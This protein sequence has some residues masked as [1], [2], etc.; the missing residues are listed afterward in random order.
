MKAL[1]DTS[2][3]VAAVVTE[4]GQHEPSFACFQCYTTGRHEGHC[5]THALAEC[6]A[7]LTALPLKRRIQPAE[8]R[9]LIDETFRSRL[10]VLELPVR[11]YADSIHRASSLGLASGVIYD[12]LHLFCAEKGGCKRLYTLN[13]GDFQRLK[14]VGVQLATP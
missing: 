9:R 11:A 13:T 4:L 7:T 12:A 2:V 10:I 3:L 1:F 14:P 5:S 8:A 6:Y